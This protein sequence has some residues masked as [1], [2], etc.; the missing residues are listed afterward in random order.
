MS[1]D[2]RFIGSGADE[3]NSEL[4][5]GQKWIR[6]TVSRYTRYSLEVCGGKIPSQF[7]A[8]IV[9]DLVPAAATNQQDTTL[10]RVSGIFVQAKAKK[11]KAHASW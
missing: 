8:L 5:C 4:G 1:F 9:D 11:W 2:L 10:H 7:I 6:D 3:V